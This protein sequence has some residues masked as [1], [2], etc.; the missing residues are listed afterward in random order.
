MRTVKPSLCSSLLFGATIAAALAV[1]MAPA[2]ARS[3]GG[4]SSSVGASTHMSTQ[5]MANTN[6]P[7][8]KDRDFGVDRAEDRMSARGRAHSQALKHRSSDNDADDKTTT[9][10]RRR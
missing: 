1:A 8:A 5:G 10:T 7:S 2:N 4:A 6:G 3:G 9:S